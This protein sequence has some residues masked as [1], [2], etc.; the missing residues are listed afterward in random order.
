[1]FFVSC[2]CV[3][4]FSATQTH[5][6][7]GT[8]TQAHTHTHTHTHTH[9][10]SLSLWLSVALS[11]Y[12]SRSFRSRLTLSACL[13]IGC[14]LDFSLATTS[15][16]TCR[17]FTSQRC[18]PILLLHHSAL[19]TRLPQSTHSNPMHD[20]AHN[21]SNLFPSPFRLNNTT[22]AR[23]ARTF[24][25]RCTVATSGRCSAWTGGSRMV[26]VEV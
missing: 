21:P 7:T 14:C 25:R 19:L 24:C 17:T 9:S 6:H 12:C 5:R 2:V 23:T 11:S 10:L 22:H 4:C 1:M 16:H 8:H 15:S 20:P 3:C 18:A 13:T 26:R